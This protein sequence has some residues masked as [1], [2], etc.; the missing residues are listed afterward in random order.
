MKKVDVK[1][2]CPGMIVCREVVSPE[3]VVLLE[4][5]MCLTLAQI[6]ILNRRG[7]QYVCIDGQD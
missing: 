4:K 3:G 7:V 6:T 1:D 5:G 2:L